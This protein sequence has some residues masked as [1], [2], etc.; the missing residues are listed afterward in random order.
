MVLQSIGAKAAKA[1][2][3]VAQAEAP[4][5][6]HVT[7]YHD[8]N[9]RKLYFWSAILCIASATTGYDGQMLNASQLMDDWQTFF[10][11]PTGA[12]LGLMNNAFNI[13]SIVSFFFVPFFTDHFGRKIPIA[14]GCLIMVG[15]VFLYMAFS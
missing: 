3:Q 10:G 5:F 1:D 11:E 7:W 15:K 13:G 14:V 2:V 6:E 12:R 4:R 8:A 9:L